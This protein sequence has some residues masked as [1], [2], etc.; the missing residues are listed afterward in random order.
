MVRLLGYRIRRRY[1]RQL[2]SWATAVCDCTEDVCEESLKC[3]KNEWDRPFA[4]TMQAIKNIVDRLIHDQMKA[5]WYNW[6]VIRA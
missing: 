1:S 4:C 2:L 3:D 6:I 5:I